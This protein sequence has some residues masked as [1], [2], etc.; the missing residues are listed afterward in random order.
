MWCWAGRGRI[1]VLACCLF[2]VAS[3][4]RF[5][6]TGR[7]FVVRGQWSLECET[8]PRLA[9][10]ATECC[11]CDATGCT[12]QP[13]GNEAF[14]RDMPA[15]AV[16][17]SKAPEAPELIAWR[18]RLKNHRLLSRLLR[19]RGSQTANP[20]PRIDELQLPDGVLTSPEPRWPDLVL[21]D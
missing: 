5:H 12:T 21:H 13:S 11:T 16:S 20:S 18:S 9:F 8:I 2:V 7:G 10:P 19:G 15:P 14:A 17:V 1:V 4:C 6:R 3:G